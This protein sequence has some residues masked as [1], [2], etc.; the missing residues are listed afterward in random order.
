MNITD[1]CIIDQFVGNDGLNYFEIE[2]TL[3]GGSSKI[4][5]RKSMFTTY[6]ATYDSIPA[7]ELDEM[8]TVTK[9]K[10]YNMKYDS[11]TDEGN[12]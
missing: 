3:R 5:Y 11:V 12:F 10:F 8:K 9:E 7:V 2:Q 4:M 6:Y 1:N